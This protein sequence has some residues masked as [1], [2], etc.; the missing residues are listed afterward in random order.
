MRQKTE[1]IGSLVLVQ[2]AGEL[3]NR[4]RN[5]EALL[6]DGA[7]ALE[8]D[9][10]GPSN[11]AAQIAGRR[12]RAA[13]TERA[14]ILREQ[15]RVLGMESVL[16]W[17]LGRGGSSRLGGGLGRGGGGLLGSSTFLGSARLKDKRERQGNK[18][19]E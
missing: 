18:V 8:A 7:L 4:R 12:Q 15:V 3:V 5:L 10:S 16:S 11:G 19:R 1:Q 2:S 14:G 9:I 17:L 13:N 6:E